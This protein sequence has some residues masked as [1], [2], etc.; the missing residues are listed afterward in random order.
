MRIAETGGHTHTP[1][2]QRPTLKSNAEK[3][4]MKLLPALACAAMMS[5]PA[6]AESKVTQAQTEVMD[7]LAALGVSTEWRQCMTLLFASCADQPVG[8][9][10]HV[11]CLGVEHDRW[12]EAME[13]E[14]LALA[15]ELTPTGVAQ[16]SHVMGQ[17]FG[18]VAQKCVGVA[19]GKPALAAE[20][21]Q[22]GCEISE[23]AG[24]T[25]EFVACRS[26][27]SQAPYCVRLK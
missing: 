2:G 14:R 4:P 21:A 20:A 17:W 6:A 5:G 25:M 16:L 27:R 13:G 22:T 11:A 15:E 1:L 24:V 26:G 7:C 8:S 3:Q 9:E 23:M 18:H 19:L 12:R 10:G